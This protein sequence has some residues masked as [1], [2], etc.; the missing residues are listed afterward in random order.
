MPSTSWSDADVGAVVAAL[1][2][3]PVLDSGPGAAKLVALQRAAPALAA[4]LAAWPQAKA[5]APA[6]AD[7][8]ADTLS[9][10]T[11][12][13]DV[14]AADGNSSDGVQMLALA[15]RLLASIAR[16]EAADGAPPQP[17]PPRLADVLTAYLADSPN[18]AMLG[19]DSP[20]VCGG[21]PG[22]LTGRD[23][24]VCAQAQWSLC[25]CWAP[26]A[27]CRCM[28]RRWTRCSGHARP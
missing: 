15:R 13:A 3:G 17:V 18:L 27:Q 6:D 7:A 19:T 9:D 10:D 25:P 23:V 28:R 2:R 24:S 16:R 22:S 4:L 14:V 1:V 11:I 12:L 26:T 20:L 8:D 5:A 21:A